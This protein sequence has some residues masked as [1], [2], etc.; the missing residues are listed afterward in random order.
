MT[1]PIGL[2][3]KKGKCLETCCRVNGP[4]IRPAFTLSAMDLVIVS[5]AKRA[6]EWLGGVKNGR[7]S[8]E[9]LSVTTCGGMPWSNPCL[10]PSITSPYFFIRPA[11]VRAFSH[12]LISISHVTVV[13]YEAEV[14]GG[15]CRC[16]S[17]GYLFLTSGSSCCVG[18]PTWLVYLSC[19]ASLI[20]SMLGIVSCVCINE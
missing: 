19:P 10:K 18:Y 5:A 14:C 2:V 20:S 4:Y 3:R 7:V 1:A 12:S 9:L 6:D 17:P 11:L 8:P 15:S 16:V 13:G